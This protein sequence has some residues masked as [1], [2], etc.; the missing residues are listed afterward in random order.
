[1]A[2]NKTA[3]EIP[4]K[5]RDRYDRI[6]DDPEEFYASLARPLPKAFRVN[7]LKAEARKA[8]ERLAGYGMGIRPVEWYDAAF[9]AEGEA[10]RKIG[11][12][13]EHF[14]GHI[15][16]QELVSMLPPLLLK[17]KIEENPD[18]AV[19]DACAAPGSKTTQLAALMG[20]RDLIVANDVAFGRLKIIKHNLEKL[21]C[22]NTV[23]INRD[24]RFF[25]PDVQFDCIL[26]DVPCSSE[27]TL[28]KNP[29]IIARWSEKAIASL[30]N[31]Q[32]Q[33][34]TRCCDMLKPG[35]TMVYSTCTF[36]PEENEAVI[37]YLIEKKSCALE[38]VRIP[39]L[40]TA[41]TVREWNGREFHH[42]VGKAVRIWPH[43][44]DTGGFFIAKIRKS[45]AI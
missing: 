37:D 28:R 45:E 43:H 24:V 38:P 30:S 36:A 39:G 4:Q 44:N 40:K 7:T 18:L 21:G 32:R 6:V 13:L 25:S 29:E 35:G 41:E 8:T 17:K 5:F 20:N 12:T 16:I 1:M 22:M 11:S 3:S 27:G 19:L 31:I 34:I 42:E 23:V 9:I 2:K 33:M 26:L 14:M 15:Y 10:G